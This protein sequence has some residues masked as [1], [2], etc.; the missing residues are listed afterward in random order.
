[1]TTGYEFL[2][3]RK[4]RTAHHGITHP[5]DVVGLP[6]LSAAEKRAILASWASDACSVPEIPLLRQLED[7]TIAMIDDILRALKTLDGVSDDNR[8][9]R[10]RALWGAPHARR[11]QNKG[12]PWPHRRRR[13][14]DDDPPPCPAYGAI[15]PR[16]GGGGAMA[17]PEPVLA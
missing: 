7:G 1:M 16:R 15:V 4:C 17:S 10:N 3:N 13:D 6:D 8:Q 5:D 11:R 12:V 14:D 2:P 9:N